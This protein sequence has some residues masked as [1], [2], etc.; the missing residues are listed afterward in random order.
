MAEADNDKNFKDRIASI[1]EMDEAYEHLGSI[2]LSQVYSFQSRGLE[3]KEELVK[4][5]K[6]WKIEG[7]PR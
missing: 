4:L 5:L 6:S 7:V 1:C 3:K 2:G